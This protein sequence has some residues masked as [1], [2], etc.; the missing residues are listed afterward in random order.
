MNWIYVLSGLIAL[1]LLFYLFVALL[2]P[3]KFE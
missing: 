2:R 1:G 3:E